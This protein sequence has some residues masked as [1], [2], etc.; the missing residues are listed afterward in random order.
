MITWLSVATLLRYKRTA[1]NVIP[2]PNPVRNGHR[3]CNPR[4]VVVGSS[5]QRETDRPIY[6]VAEANP[7]GRAPHIVALD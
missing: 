3:V 1:I 6:P 7:T 5:E 2:T 4:K